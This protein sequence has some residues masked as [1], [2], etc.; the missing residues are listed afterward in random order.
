MPSFLGCNVGPPSIRLPSQLP[1]PYWYTV[2]MVIWFFV[3]TLKDGV[4]DLFDVLFW[5][6]TKQGWNP[7]IFR[8]VSHSYLRSCLQAVVLSLAPV[9]IFPTS[10]ID[11]SFSLTFSS[12]IY[13]VN[14]LLQ[15]VKIINDLWLA[16]VT[17]FLSFTY[18][19]SVSWTRC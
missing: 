15:L 1:K 12:S 11:R 17:Q 2:Y 3:E 16:L 18:T 4:L 14:A 6:D 5:Q 7:F 13:I 10:I 9:K 8:A 19:F